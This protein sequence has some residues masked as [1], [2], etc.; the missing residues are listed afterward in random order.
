LVTLEE[1]TYNDFHS[2]AF[3]PRSGS[4]WRR[5][6]DITLLEGFWPG[7]TLKQART[8]FG[9]EDSKGASSKGQFWLYE[10][11]KGTIRISLEDIGSTILPVD[12]KW[13]V[14]AIPRDQRI[15]AV[16][17][18]ELVGQIP[19]GLEDFEAAVLNQCGYTAIQVTV[20]G[21]KVT[22]IDWLPSPGSMPLNGK[23]GR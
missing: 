2:L 6:V 3:R 12:R 7:I 16:F 15:E 1:D 5:C 9:P 19:S 8:T 10:R 13:R 22:R 14:R 11:P 17:G 4:S 23:R 21:G 20:K 18:P